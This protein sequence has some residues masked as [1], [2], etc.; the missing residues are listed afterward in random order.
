MNGDWLASSGVI[1]VPNLNAD[2]QSSLST[3]DTHLCTCS[4]QGE[5]P[6]S[7]STVWAAT[8]Y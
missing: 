3:G 4:V 6:E 1:A 8:D 7:F 2:A 5:Q